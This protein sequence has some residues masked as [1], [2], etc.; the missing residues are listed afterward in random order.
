MN[1]ERS[2][3]LKVVLTPYMLRRSIWYAL[4]LTHRSTLNGPSAHGCNLDMQRLG[5]HSLCRRT[6]T[7]CLGWN[8]IFLR[9]LLACF[10]YVL[11]IFSMLVLAYSWIFLMRSA[12]LLASMLTRSYTGKGKRSMGAAELNTYTIWKGEKFVVECTALLYANSTW[13]RLSSHIFKFFFSIARNNMDNVRYTTS[14]WSSVC[15]W[16]VVEKSNCVPSLPHSVF[17]K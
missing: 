17:Q 16:H 2:A 8:T 13:G 3:T 5:N 12:C 1:G 15:G 10:S 14:V 11:V 4:S 7:S 9:P 6:Q